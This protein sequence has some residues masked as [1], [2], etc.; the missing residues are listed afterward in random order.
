MSQCTRIANA[1][2]KGGWKVN[3]LS[4]SYPGTTISG[5]VLKKQENK[6]TETIQRLLSESGF[7]A[8]QQIDIGDPPMSFG[9]PEKAYPVTILIGAHIPN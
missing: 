5:I 9:T 7:D 3:S 4:A 8:V 2:E 6:E 1:F